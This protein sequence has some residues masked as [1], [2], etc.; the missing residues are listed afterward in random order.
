M[1]TLLCDR[2]CAGGTWLQCY[3]H[4][5]GYRQAVHHIDDW[6]PLVLD[7][8][9]PD[10]GEAEIKLASLPAKAG[11]PVRR[12]P[13]SR[14]SHRI[15]TEYWMP[16]F[17]GMTAEGLGKDLRCRLRT[18]A[19]QLR[20]QQ[21]QRDGEIGRIGFQFAGMNPARDFDQRLVRRSRNS[22]LAAFL[23]HEAVY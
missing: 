21:F 16:A 4:R 7:A 13:T 6:R 10:G 17:A 14:V 3:R 15:D 2:R 1:G 12:F 8:I 22:A 9:G 5:P 19:V 23:D 20:V 18:H 11:N